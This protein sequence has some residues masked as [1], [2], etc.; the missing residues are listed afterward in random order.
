MIPNNENEELNIV[1]KF[2]VDG[3]DYT[4]FATTETM[5]CFGCHQEGHFVRNCPE[6]VHN[7][8]ETVQG[9]DDAGEGTSAGTLAR[10]SAGKGGKGVSASDARDEP[11]HSMSEMER[12]AEFQDVR[13]LAVRTPVRLSLLLLKCVRSLATQL[14]Q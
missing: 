9:S 3:F 14:R 1:M 8:A 5:R 11:Q 2:K 7:E 13:L 12:R 10:V 6:K 4:I